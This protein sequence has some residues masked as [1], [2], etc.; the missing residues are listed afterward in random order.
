LLLPYFVFVV[1]LRFVILKEITEKVPCFQNVIKFIPRDSCKF[2]GKGNLRNNFLTTD[3]ILIN[4]NFIINIKC[5]V[6]LYQLNV[7]NIV[8]LQR[9]QASDSDVLEFAPVPC[10]CMPVRGS[11]Y[12][13]TMLEQDYEN[14]CQHFKRKISQVSFLAKIFIHNPSIDSLLQMRVIQRHLKYTMFTKIATM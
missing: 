12:F 4:I 10:V 3:Y 11:L 14:V 5:Y 7:G 8:N 2:L 1:K 13:C 6:V 9:I